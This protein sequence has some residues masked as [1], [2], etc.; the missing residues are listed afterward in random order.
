MKTNVLFENELE[1]FRQRKERACRKEGKGN[2]NNKV[3]CC[4]WDKRNATNKNKIERMTHEKEIME[5]KEVQKVP[6]IS[7]RSKDIVKKL[8]RECK[9]KCDMKREDSRIRELKEQRQRR[10][11]LIEMLC[12]KRRVQKEEEEMKVKLCAVQHTTPSV[13][14]CSNS[15]KENDN[16]LM[17]L[18]RRINEYYYKHKRIANHGVMYHPI[19]RHNVKHAHTFINNNTYSSY[20][21]VHTH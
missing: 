20:Q 9:Y 2:G 19:N 5:M 7:Q 12:M 18:R 11:T 8:N 4:Y 13:T 6:K 15:N 14:A 1:V 17:Q 3:K 10:I 16:E 21:Y